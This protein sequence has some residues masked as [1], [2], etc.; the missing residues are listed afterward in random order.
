MKVADSEKR[1]K[2]ATRSVAPPLPL[3]RLDIQEELK[4]LRFPFGNVT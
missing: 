1:N 2:P 4:I 3:R